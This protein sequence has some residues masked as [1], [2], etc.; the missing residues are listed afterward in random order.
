MD[1]PFPYALFLGDA[2]PLTAKTATGIAHWRPERCV[3]QVV[4]PGCSVDLRLPTLSAAGAAEAGARLLIVGVADFGGKIAERWVPTLLAALE[5]DLDVASGLHQRL[6]DIPA[7]AQAAGRLGRHLF[8]IRQPLPEQIPIA[9]GR[10]RSGK[11]LLTVGTDCA[12]GKMFASLAVERALRRRGVAASFRATGQTGI[13]IAGS[14]VSVDAV[15]S[16][17]VAGAAEALSPANE[18]DHWDII[19]GQGSLHHPAYAGV[20]LGLIHGSQPDALVLCHSIERDHIDGC[21]A[22]PTPTLE[23]AIE[24]NERAAR[25][26]N[27]QAQVI[28]VSVNTSRATE[29]NAREYLAQIETALGLPCC[30]PVRTG[31]DSI[32]DRLCALHK[33]EARQWT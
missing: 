2:D 11:R 31:V 8:D 20:T 22:Y 27:P 19:E 24:D 3:A 15:V 14:G 26:T 32:V 12:V 21:P 17:F 29:K 7:L 9:N 18:A 6:A 30:D 4:L 28:G 16:D 10:K 5:S 25:L 23:R 13:F 33:I 1:L